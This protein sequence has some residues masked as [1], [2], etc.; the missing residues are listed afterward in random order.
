MGSL[1]GAL[2]VEA[3]QVGSPTD[4]I[5]FSSART[6]YCCS[7]CHCCYCCCRY[8]CYWCC[9]CPA[10]AA[11]TAATAA[12]TATTAA[13][14]L[15][16]W[17]DAGLDMLASG[18]S[19]LLPVLLGSACAAAA[20]AAWFCLC[21][22][23]LWLYLRWRCWRSLCRCWLV[24]WLCLL[25]AGSASAGAGA[26][27]AFPAFPG[28]CAGSASA[29][30][31]PGSGFRIIHK[32]TQPPPLL[33]LLLQNQRQHLGRLP[34]EGKVHAPALQMKTESVCTC[35]PP[36]KAPSHPHCLPLQNQRQHPWG[37][38]PEVHAPALQ[39]KKESVCT[40]WFTYIFKT[41]C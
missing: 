1:E 4:L 29:G 24:C 11:T 39:M 7:H 23:L 16:A 2:Q 9:H 14:L 22:L 31:G 13:L 5:G 15:P 35:L 38:S 19:L 20:G 8:C 21:C 36:L 30:A 33:S 10:T 18:L 40:V 3:S 26:R 25:S 32:S 28:G 6:C 17:A 34:K 41:V 27:W 12:A 37:D